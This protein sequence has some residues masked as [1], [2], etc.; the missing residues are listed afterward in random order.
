MT[1]VLKVSRSPEMSVLSPFPHSSPWR[2]THRQTYLMN[3][4]GLASFSGCGL[5]HI[6][7]TPVT[8][9]FRVLRQDGE[10][11]QWGEGFRQASRFSVIL[12]RSKPISNLEW[13][14]IASSLQ[15]ASRIYC[16]RC[17]AGS[18]SSL[19]L[20]NPSG[21]PSRSFA[22]GTTPSGSP[23]HSWCVVVFH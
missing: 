8:P 18:T 19:V 12:M 16:K 9:S 1:A 4:L 3:H 21:V 14:M 17:Q 2:K 10:R 13:A 5:S 20:L 6:A 7:R 22:C 11:G 15:T 23:G